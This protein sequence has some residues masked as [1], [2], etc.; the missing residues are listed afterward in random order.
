M[1]GYTEEPLCSCVNVGDVTLTI[2]NEEHTVSGIVRFD[3]V[4]RILE[5]D[6]LR[7]RTD[8]H[9]SIDPKGD[10]SIKI[11]QQA[12]ITLSSKSIQGLFKNERTG[13]IVHITLSDVAFGSF[14]F[15]LPTEFDAGVEHCP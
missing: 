5:V 14:N 12:I 3:A 4:Q 1:C 13:K 7:E 6:N 10:E 2:N 15:G 8:A 11:V 9:G